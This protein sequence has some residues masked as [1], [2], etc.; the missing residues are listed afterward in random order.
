MDLVALSAA[1]SQ[2]RCGPGTVEWI[3]AGPVPQLHQSFFRAVMD[4]RTDLLFPRAAL[5]HAGVDVCDPAGTLSSRQRARLL[6]GGGV[7]DADGDG[8]GGWGA[9]GCGTLAAVARRGRG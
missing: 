3:P 4:W 2:A 1:H 9:L 7:P 8:S 6:P 5:S